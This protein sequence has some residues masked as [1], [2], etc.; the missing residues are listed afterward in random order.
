MTT[1]IPKFDLKDGGATPTGA[2]NRPI[3]EKLAEVVSVKD[4]G[5][6]GD[7]VTNDSTAFSNA[8]A[9]GKSIFV[10]KGTYLININIANRTVIYGDGSTASIIKPFN[11][12]I[13]AMTY[14]YV[15]A[16]WTYHS[17]IHNI[18]FTGLGTKTGVGFTFGQTVPANYQTNDEF[19]R[20]VKFYGCYF[21]N[22][23]KG[24]QFPFGNIG[25]EFYSCGFQSNYYGVYAL[26]NKFGGY[27]MHAGNKY[28]YSGEMSANDCAVYIDNSDADGFGAFAFTDTVLEGNKIALYLKNINGTMTTPVTMQNVWLEINGS[29]QGGTTV[30]DSWSGTTKTTQTVTNKTLIIEG[31]FVFFNANDSQFT[32]ANI[33]ATNSIINVVNCRTESLNSYNGGACTVADTSV[34]NFMNCQANSVFPSGKN[35]VFSGMTNKWGLP[36][37]GGATNADKYWQTF[38][39]GSKIT[40]YGSSLQTTVPFTSAEATTGSFALTGSVVSDG[41]IYSTCNEFTRAAFLSSEFTSVINT[42]TTLAVGWYVYTVDIKVTVGALTFNIWNRG[43]KQM[44]R[45]FTCPSVGDWYSFAGIG[46]SDAASGQLYLDATGTG[47]NATWRL[48]AWQMHKFNT[49][50]QAQAFLNSYAYAAS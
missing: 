4:F 8:I 32:D 45:N 18:G 47:V 26:N 50:A 39:R 43:T 27:G 12:A 30:I 23:E 46:Y 37:D 20:N 24:I 31:N 41:A 49:L 13:A 35:I 9:T 34:L 36:I 25:T 44:A 5:A 29:M 21:S 17:E 19:T 7:G 15:D 11:V 10:P 40:S 48:S 14:K 33:T 3:N 16:A 38:P 6:V 28:F 22:L 42:T 1:L 2:V